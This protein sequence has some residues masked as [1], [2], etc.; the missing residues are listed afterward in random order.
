MKRHMKIVILCLF[1]LMLCSCGW[2][3][4]PEG[5]DEDYSDIETGFGGFVII[6]PDPDEMGYYTTGS[7][8]SVIVVDYDLVDVGSIIVN[9]SNNGSYYDITCSSIG[10]GVFCGIIDTS[11]YSLYGIITV[12][13][14]DNDPL[15]VNSA[16]F[17]MPT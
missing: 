4:N 6:P 3:E 16:S 7:Y 12:T 14:F 11:L 10:E 5:T 13:Y 17:E 15:I 2:F 9:I 1:V 8:I